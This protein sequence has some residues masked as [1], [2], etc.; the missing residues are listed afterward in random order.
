[1]V[2]SW[3]QNGLRMPKIYTE[4]RLRGSALSRIAK[5]LTENLG[6]FLYEIVDKE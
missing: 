6:V 2:R 1:M 3:E 4:L 5:D